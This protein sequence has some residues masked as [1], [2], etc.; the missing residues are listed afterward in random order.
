MK[1]EKTRKHEDI[2]KCMKEATHRAFK[3]VENWVDEGSIEGIID[4]DGIVRRNDFGDLE[5]G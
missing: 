5:N 2:R 3:L 4:A 1:M